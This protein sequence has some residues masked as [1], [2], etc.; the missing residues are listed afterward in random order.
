[1][2]PPIAP[3]ENRTHPSQGGIIPITTFRNPAIYLLVAGALLVSPLATG[4]ALALCG[5][6]NA[7]ATI[8]VTDLVQIWE[9]LYLGGPVPV[10]LADGDVD[11][12][13]SIDASDI[14]YLAAY[15][16]KGGP[17]PCTSSICTLPTG[18]NE[19]RLT[20]PTQVWPGTVDSI[21]VQVTFTNDIPID[22]LSL[23]IKHNSPY[24]EITSVNVSS[25]LLP[26]PILSVSLDPANNEVIIA[27]IDVAF[28]PIAAQS[29]GLLADLW[30]EVPAGAP[31]HTID[32]QS[33]F[34]P[35]GTEA[36]FAATG[37]GTI[38]PN[39]V[40]CGTAD[41][42]IGSG[43]P[44]GD[45]DCSGGVDIDDVVYLIN[46]IFGGGSDPCFGCQ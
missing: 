2:H 32:I 15:I 27:S 21:A 34:I 6:V 26:D 18:S 13:G 17:A 8:N 9:Y 30:F 33:V 24:I 29:G 37:G 41:L 43:N 42:I 36:L 44:C 5:D 10:A 45:V 39:F 35:P 22:G 1:L 12:C 11:L 46:Y 3:S 38:Y 25:S 19:V 7:D 31:N 14:A 4:S 40:D 16:F 20:C 23:G 28:S